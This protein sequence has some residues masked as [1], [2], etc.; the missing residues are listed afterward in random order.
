[1]ETPI[2]PNQALTPEQSFRSYIAA[3]NLANKTVNDLYYKL[4]YAVTNKMGPMMGKKVATKYHERG[5]RRSGYIDGHFRNLGSRIKDILD[6]VIATVNIP[7]VTLELANDQYLMN[8][9]FVRVL[10]KF[11]KTDGTQANVVQTAELFKFDD[12]G[13]VNEILQCPYY[14]YDYTYEGNEEHK[15]EIKK[16]EQ[17]IKDLK[18]KYR[19]LRSH[20]PNATYQSTW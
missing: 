6:S 9:V 4:F 16:L 3:V 2:N 7:G 19:M 15:A 10:V 8:K 12:E 1:M 5:R 18:A 11:V 17:Q 20:D 13:N 14:G